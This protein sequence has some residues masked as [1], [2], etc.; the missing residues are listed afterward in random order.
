[1]NEFVFNI[2]TTANVIW[3]RD[4]GLESHPLDRRSRG[5]E[6]GTSGYKASG[7]FT[8]PRQLLKF[9]GYK[10]SSFSG[11]ALAKLTTEKFNSSRAIT[12]PK[13]VT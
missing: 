12:W 6:L 5:F 10:K 1:M 4:H 9:G 2:P 8:T 11:V 7:L 3:R 13:S